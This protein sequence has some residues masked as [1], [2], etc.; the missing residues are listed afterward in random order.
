MTTQDEDNRVRITS[1]KEFALSRL[2][3]AQPLRDLL[4]SEPDELSTNEFL[5]KC[6]VWL[7]LLRQRC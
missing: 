6:E 4:L 1:L 2:S 5:I 3:Q 7:K